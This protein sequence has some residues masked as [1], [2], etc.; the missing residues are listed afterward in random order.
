MHRSILTLLVAACCIAAPLFSAEPQRGVPWP[1]IENDPAKL[2]AGVLVEFSGL[3]ERDWYRVTAAPRGNAVA[4][5]S[6]NGHILLWDAENATSV[7]LDASRAACHL[8]FSPDGQTLA[9]L[10]TVFIEGTADAAS[11]EVH[12]WRKS[13]GSWRVANRIK[14]Q[15]AEMQL[16]ICWSPDGRSLA[17]TFGKPGA[18]V[19]NAESGDVVWRNP[20]DAFQCRFSRDGRWFA[21]GSS[22]NP[23]VWEWPSGRQVWKSESLAPT[24]VG[25]EF[26]GRNDLLWAQQSAAAIH[27]YR[28]SQG[29][30]SEMLHL[31]QASGRLQVSPDGGLLLMDSGRSVVIREL[32]TRETLCTVSIPRGFLSRDCTTCGGR[33][34]TSEFGKTTVWDV[35][36]LVR[37]SLPKEERERVSTE[38]ELW[39][40]LASA[41]RGAGF[42]AFWTL[43][44]KGAALVPWLQARL[45]AERCSAEEF[46]RL[47]GELDADEPALRDAVRGRLRKAV[48]LMPEELKKAVAAAETV[49]AAAV[50]KG[51]QAEL[52]ADELAYIPNPHV[53][54]GVR[55][56]HLL[57][58]AR[59]PEALAILHELAKSD[60]PD[61]QDAVR[62]ILWRIPKPPAEP[63]EQGKAPPA[64]QP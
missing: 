15:N 9:A 28:L 8:A 4:M 37:A 18:I 34:V 11:T 32:W 23:S 13:E 51:L 58:I 33:L 29:P 36:A 61:L 27:H 7:A 35:P 52:A 17:T 56:A 54:R 14:V 5:S 43:A 1:N 50:L 59:T 2:P 16:S 60:A 38:D 22:R 6:G 47:A 19:L 39:E 55:V 57:E 21:A 44:G 20:I 25:L 41:K 24:I 26:V 30:P 10:R 49:E 62:N 45:D 12:L 64:T 40:E 48:W 46:A 53:R 42:L 31:R 3:S 63:K